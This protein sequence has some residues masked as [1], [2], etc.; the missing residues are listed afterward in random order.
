MS[1]NG[2]VSRRKFLQL[3]AAGVAASGLALSGCAPAAA[4]AAA[5]T[6]A[7]AAPTAAV[8]NASS[9]HLDQTYV[10]L[11][12]VTS[13]AFWLDGRKGLEAAGQQLGVKTDFLGPVEYDAAQQ[14]KILDELIGKKPAGIMIFP[15]D[16]NSLSDS[17]KRAMKEGIPVLCVNSDVA[18][19]TARYGFVGPDNRGVGRT[20]GQMV[21]Q[22]LNGKGNVAIMT[23]PGIEVHES[24]AGGYKDALANY[25]DI[26]IVDIVNDKSDPA[27]GV[28]VATQLV[29]AHPD[30]DLIIGTDATAGAAIARALKETGKAGKVKVMAMDRDQ[31][32]LPYIQDGTISATLAQNSTLEEWLATT[33]LY[34]LKNN[35]VPTFDDWRAANAPQVPKFTDVGVSVVT[36]DNVGFYLKK[37]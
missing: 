9:Q 11:C 28:T 36:K 14:L 24:R 12:A 19:P 8:S 2:E 25:P 18:D 15:A 10:W 13:V 1:K 22:L 30:L 16:A 21:A 6:Q 26:K 20:G 37:S 17:M 5:P 34:W 27:V 23:V 7:A 33:Y 4:P 35:S 31:D 29:Q 32:M 3:S